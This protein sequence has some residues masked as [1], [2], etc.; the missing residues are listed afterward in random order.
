MTMTSL[1]GCG[2]N[3]IP[4]STLISKR[5]RRHLLWASRQSS[6]CSDQQAGRCCIHHLHVVSAASTIER[7]SQQSDV[8]TSP[9]QH[10]STFRA[11][12]DFKAL[13]ADLDRHVKNCKDR[14]SSADPAKIA[15]LYDK[16]C[17][18]QQRVD[19]VREDRNSNAKAMK[20]QTASLQS[21]AAKA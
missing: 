11:F 18:A 15:K 3:V 5:L 17:E 21:S 20:V 2:R 7:Q 14:N 8:V 10:K 6:R 1:C 9:Q 19:K 12:L 16:Y 13:K 4:A